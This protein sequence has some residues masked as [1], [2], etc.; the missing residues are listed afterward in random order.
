MGEVDI[1][2]ERGV[3]RITLNRPEAINALTH[4]MVRAV[5]AALVAW[6]ADD[7]V[8]S[9]LLD[10]AG[11]RG[12][13][14]GGDIRAVHRDAVAGGTA[15]PGFWADEY[16]L[17][18]RI[19]RFPKPY[20]ALMDGLVMGGGVGVSAHGSVRVVTERTRLAM[21]EVG[22]GLAPDVGGTY[23][24]SRA[25]GE[26]GTY[27][28]LTGGVLSG[29]DAVHCGLADFLVPSGRLDALREGADVTAPAVEVGPSRLA[30]NR[31]W[32][33]A[34]FAADTVEEIL[35]RLVAHG[36]DATAKEIAAKSPTA[37]KVTL[38]ALR[39][40]R[41]L[42]DLEAVLEQEYRVSVACLRD[43]DLVEG[44]R[45]QIIDK[46]RSPRWSP[47]TLSGVDDDAVAAH[48]AEPEVP[49]RLT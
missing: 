34:C 28:A 40:A 9:V 17:N 7:G 36:E 26:S 11:D 2:V 46:D 1:R 15:T 31:T 44:I 41:A 30:A 48:F 16:R 13:C 6:A 27:A 45:A 12:L 21:P 39:R 3:G 22:I 5:D 35:D 49:F 14:A 37:L 38:A 20:T 42:P 24:L 18:A 32:I 8:R 23:L 29:A 19:A 33:D 10:G 43:H 25:P 4:D 47:A